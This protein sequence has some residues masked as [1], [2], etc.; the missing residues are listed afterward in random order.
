MKMEFTEEEKGW[1]EGHLKYAKTI[2]LDEGKE[3]DWRTWEEIKLS[4]ADFQSKLAAIPRISHIALVRSE[5]E[6]HILILNDLIHQ[7]LL[8]VE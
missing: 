5:E 2:D 4:S 6:R 8:S 1:L 7:G 3:E